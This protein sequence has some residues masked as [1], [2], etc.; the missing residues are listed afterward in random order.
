MSKVFTP[1]SWAARGWCR[2]ER[3]CRELSGTES[4]YIIIKS[5]T[6]FELTSST[7]GSF[8]GPPGEG[9]F[10][11]AADRTKLGPVLQKALHRKLLMLLEAQDFVGYRV[12][13]N[14]QAVLLRGFMVQPMH[15]I[16]PADR[17]IEANLD[18]AS[19]E[20]ADFLLQNGFAAV[21]DVDSC[22]W[23]PMHYAALRGEPLLIQSLIEQRADPDCKAKKANPKH[24]TTLAGVSALDLCL[25]HR[26]NEAARLLI[27]ANANVNGA[28]GLSSACIGDN[29]EGV[30]M[31][32]EAGC[33][34]RHK[35]KYGTS[36]IRTA[37]M[38][39]SL[40]ALQ[41]LVS[42]LGPSLEPK[43]LSQALDIATIFRG[44]GEL[45]KRLIDLKADVNEKMELKWDAI[46]IFIRLKALH[47]KFG[48]DSPLT[49]ICYH[50][51]GRTPLMAAILILFCMG[52]HSS[53]QMI[54][55][56]LQ[57]FPCLF[58]SSIPTR[59]PTTH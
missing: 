52:P 1:A 50:Y 39:G 4:S 51:A 31:L 32:C 42:Q 57:K 25:V 26:N 53:S 18:V 38:F 45:V 2:I 20:V 37:C 35:D 58:H 56:R 41:E 34:P 9:T 47:L 49:L 40:W 10:T 55:Q 6:Q 27:A 46:S 16:L 13:M 33:S 44:H 19:H 17:E 28:W 7:V 22:G 21:G 54:P 48:M 5:K 36:G 59:S 14:L 15:T 8:G 11:V 29:A 24:G 23:S 12:W 3:L 30:R 43:D